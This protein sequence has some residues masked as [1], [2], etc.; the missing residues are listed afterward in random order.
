MLVG[1]EARQHHGLEAGPHHQ[2]DAS[3]GDVL[4]SNGAGFGHLVHGRCTDGAGDHTPIVVECK[5]DRGRETL[6][7]SSVADLQDG[8]VV[9]LRLDERGVWRGEGREPRLLGCGNHDVLRPTVSRHCCS[10][11]MSEP[12]LSAAASLAK[13]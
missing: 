11:L 13:P 5:G 7:I 3:T 10:Y 4:P 6:D 8:F 12:D 1:V 2:V 9:V